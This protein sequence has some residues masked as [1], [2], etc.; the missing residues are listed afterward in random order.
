M[1]RLI[2]NAVLLAASIAIIFVYIKP[3]YEDASQGIV[4]LQEKKANLLQARS[5]LD[6]LKRKQTELFALR[7]QISQEDLNRL[8]RLLPKEINPVLFIMELDTIAR[9]QGMSLKNIKFDDAKKELTGT[10]LPS[11]TPKKTYE[12]FTVTF[13]VAGRYQNF[14]TFLDLVEQGLRVTDV[15]SVAL[16]ANDKV[17]IYQY[18]VKAQT[19]WMK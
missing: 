14:S 17:D 16:T 18:T 1:M 4:A 9:D 2:F 12:T 13:D 7:N 19:Y 10:T 15:T 3:T 6:V 11:A 5:D 8:E